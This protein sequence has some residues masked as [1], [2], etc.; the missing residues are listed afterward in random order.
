VLQKVAAVFMA[1]TGLVARSVSL[2][3]DGTW[4]VLSAD[5]RLFRYKTLAAKKE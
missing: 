1:T 3:A 5:G 2:T 4:Y